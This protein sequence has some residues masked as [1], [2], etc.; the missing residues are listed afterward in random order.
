MATKKEKKLE[1]LG[2]QELAELFGKPT[3]TVRQWRQRGQLPPPD[4]MVSGTPIW[5]RST[6]DAWDDGPRAY[7]TRVTTG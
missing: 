2:I 1:L 6:I 3:N 4:Y 7:R 5:E